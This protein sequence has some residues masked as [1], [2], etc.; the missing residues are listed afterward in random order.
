VSVASVVNVGR[1]ATAVIVA[2]ALPLGADAHAQMTGAPAP[3]YRREAGIPASTVPAP[4]RE[5]GF[6]QRI[7]VKLPLDVVLRDEHGQLRPFGD[8]FASRPAILAFVYYECPMLCTLV[9]NSMASTLGVLSLDAG[10][11]FDLI[12]VSID[13]REGAPQAAARKAYFLD[14]YERPTAAAG[15]HFL[16]GEESSIR[17]LASAAGFRYVWDEPT[18]QYAHPA[19]VVVVTPDGRVARY[20]FG[21]DYSPRDVR[22]ALLE[23]SAGK[24]GSAIDAV[25]LY[26]YH[27][28][29]MTGRYGF[30]IMRALRVAGVATVLAIGGFVMVSLRRERRAGRARRARLAPAAQGPPSGGPSGG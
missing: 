26:C 8:Y 27:Y 5:I 11:D 3:G 18:Q 28:D 20:L 1:V 15:T 19:G 10:S 6:D 30:V 14:R 12:A 22:L 21:L 2:A 13:P 23:A 9:L 7:D 24:V 17:A 29:P 16:T 4:L 25:M